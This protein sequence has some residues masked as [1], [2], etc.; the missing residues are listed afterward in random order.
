[1][2]YLGHTYTEKKN[3]FIWNSGFAGFPV[4]YLAALKPRLCSQWGADMHNPF[5]S[6]IHVY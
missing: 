6:F 5:Y 3:P 1:M 4:F 2:Q